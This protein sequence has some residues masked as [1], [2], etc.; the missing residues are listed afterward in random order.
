MLSWRGLIAQI[1]CQPCATTSVFYIVFSAGVPGFLL[2]YL[3]APFSSQAFAGARCAM[4]VGGSPDS[5]SSDWELVQ[6]GLSLPGGSSS[7]TS[8]CSS[9]SSWVLVPERAIEQKRSCSL[10]GVLCMVTVSAVISYLAYYSLILLGWYL[11]EEHLAETQLF[12]GLPLPAGYTSPFAV[13]SAEMPTAWELYVGLP[14]TCCLLVSSCACCMVIARA[15]ICWIQ[16][17]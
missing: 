14:I 8:S 4:V 3:A 2:V 17:R 12:L 10:V 9:S 15:S 5:R 13:Q 7:P 16:R 11:V 1:L 6:D